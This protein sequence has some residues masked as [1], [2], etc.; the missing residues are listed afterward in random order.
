MSD[1]AEYTEEE[2]QAIPQT[3]QVFDEKQHN[4]DLQKHVLIQ[5]GYELIDMCPG[6]P[7]RSFTIPN[8]TMLVKQGGQYKIVD[9]I[10]RK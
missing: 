7:T 10:T 2:L 8:G 4:I 1:T 9:E 3:E 6:C 5:Q